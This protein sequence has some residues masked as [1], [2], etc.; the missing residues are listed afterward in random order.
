MV[1]VIT[2]IG[3]ALITA[4]VYAAVVGLLQIWRAILGIDQ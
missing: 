1:R 2:L 3:A 4:L